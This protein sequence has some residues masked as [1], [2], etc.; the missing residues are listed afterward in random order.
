ML[1]SALGGAIGCLLALPLNNVTTGIGSFATFS[2]IAFQISVTPAV[3]AVGVG[4]GLL[5]GVF[6]GLFPARSAAKK[7]ILT[8]LREI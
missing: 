1:L 8:A 5:M 2:E 6:G 3:M 7:E 4:F